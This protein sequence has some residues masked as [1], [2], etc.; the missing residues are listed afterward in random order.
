MEIDIWSFLQLEKGLN[1]RIESNRNIKQSEREKHTET[2]NLGGSFSLAYILEI[3]NAAP[4]VNQKTI[5]WVE[6]CQL[7]SEMGVQFVFCLCVGGCWYGCFCMISLGGYVSLAGHSAGRGDIEKP[8]KQ[9]TGKQGERERERG[10]LRLVY[11]D[12]CFYPL[13]YLCGLS[14][15]GERGEMKRRLF[16]IGERPAG[17]SQWGKNA[18]KKILLYSI[19]IWQGCS[20]E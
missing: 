20:T 12:A 17:R 10:L 2:N 9:G 19:S 11:R 16:C 8:C 18:K 13:S 15:R 14:G 3:R 5:E 1:N 6:F 4:P 7:S